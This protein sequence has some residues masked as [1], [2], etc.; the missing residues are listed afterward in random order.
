M[1]DTETV[2][3]A[4]G[5]QFLAECPGRAQGREGGSWEAQGLI[6]RDLIPLHRLRGARETSCINIFLMF[7]LRLWLLIIARGHLGICWVRSIVGFCV[8]NQDIRHVNQEEEAVKQPK[9]F[10]YLGS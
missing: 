8:W 7:F 9:V 2:V 6:L 5:V 1:G 3:T 10:V 4:R